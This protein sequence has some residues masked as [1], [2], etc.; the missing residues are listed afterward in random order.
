MRRFRFKIASLLGAILVLGVGFAALRESSD[1]WE[2]GIFTGTI[3]VLLLSIL[4]A[5]QR[6]ESGRAFW[7]GFALAGWTYLVLTAVPSLESKLI[8]SMALTYIDSN[9]PGRS[10]EI[11]TT[12][13]E[14]L[15]IANA[16]R[17]ATQT[18]DSLTLW[19]SETPGSGGVWT[20]S[21][22]NFVRIGHSLFALGLGWLGGQLSHR[23]CQSSRRES[24]GVS[25]F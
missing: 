15:R 18:L 4:L 13:P 14:I 21:T 19:K 9:L 17:P 16:N 7:L 23:L 10:F 8:T 22:A 20:G 5:A 24:S 3:G 11:H 12:L 6:R 2:S 1:F 25:G